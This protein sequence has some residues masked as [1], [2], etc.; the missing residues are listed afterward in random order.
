[1][2]R[3]S[4]LISMFSFLPLTPPLSSIQTLQR[5][6]MLFT[7]GLPWE[8]YLRSVRF[9]RGLENSHRKSSNQSWLSTY[10]VPC[11]THL[12]ALPLSLACRQLNVC[13]R[14]KQ[15]NGWLK[16][17]DLDRWID[18]WMGGWVVSRMNDFNISRHL[19]GIQIS[20]LLLILY[21]CNIVKS[22]FLM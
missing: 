10:Y 6:I 15:M 12:W 2:G 13:W 18:G 17:M 11:W 21:F 5:G 20:F 1:M 3:D 19:P 9:N 16:W 7:A 22:I 4:A 14:N 8:I